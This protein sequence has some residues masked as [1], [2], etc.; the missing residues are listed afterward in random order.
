MEH[1]WAIYFDGEYLIFVRSWLREIFVVAKTVQENSE[2]IIKNIYGEFTGNEKPD[3]TKAVLNFLLISHSIGEITPAPLPKELEVNTRKAG[4]WAFSS[5]GKM[6]QIGTFDENF[7]LALWPR[8]QHIE[9]NINSSLYKFETSP[10][11][12]F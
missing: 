6:A 5:F 8:D 2:L 12:C 4:L 11:I 1:K 3:F 10:Y 7:I 9:F